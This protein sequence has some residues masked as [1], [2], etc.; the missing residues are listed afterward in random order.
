MGLSIYA[1]FDDDAL[2]HMSELAIRYTHDGS[3]SDPVD[4]PEASLDSLIR[5]VK[6]PFRRRGK[7]YE[8][9]CRIGAVF[10]DDLAGILPRGQPVHL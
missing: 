2:T 10:L 4:E 5:P 9:P 6:L 1:D 7:E 3:A 8:E